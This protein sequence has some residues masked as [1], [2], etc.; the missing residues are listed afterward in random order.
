MVK[1]EDRVIWV[2]LDQK[3]GILLREGYL[4]VPLEVVE[5]PEV[6]KNTIQVQISIEKVKKA[7]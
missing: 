6:E 2:D 4:P 5:T 7:I 3:R 1:G